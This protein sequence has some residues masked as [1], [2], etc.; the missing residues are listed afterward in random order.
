MIYDNADDIILFIVQI[1][2]GDDDNEGIAAADDAGGETDMPMQGF[3][4]LVMIKIIM[5]G[6]KMIMM[7]IKMVM[8]MINIVKMMVKMVRLTCQRRVSPLY[9]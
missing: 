2:D 9:R 1:N 3:L 8:M 7:M 4:P 5:M 6:I